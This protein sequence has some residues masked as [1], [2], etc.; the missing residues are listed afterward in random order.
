ML[1]ILNK[2][3]SHFAQSRGKNMVEGHELAFQ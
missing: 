1:T 3:L 2:Y